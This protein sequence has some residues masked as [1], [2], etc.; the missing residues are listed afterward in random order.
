MKGSIYARESENDTNKAPPIELQVKRGLKW[1][2]ENGY[3]L[4]KAYQDNG[5]SGGDWRRA[6]F[7]QLI[8]DAKRHQ[9]VIVWTWNQDRLARDTEQFLKFYRELKESYVKVYSDTEGWIDMETAGGR[10]KH[11][12]LAMA[13]EAFR[14]I[15]S[16]K[17]KK[18]YQQK[19]KEA[20]NKGL[21]HFWGRKPIKLPLE[22]IK[23]LKQTGL[24][25]RAIAKE[26]S[27]ENIKVSYMTI[28][29]V[30]KNTH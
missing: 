19:R 22:Q 30:L 6:D 3:E 9:F 8:K 28:R 2:Q 16:E 29:N 11:T 13:S 7:N 27:K 1:L 25:Y 15:T 4:F 21:Q 26:L 18:V 5:F 17:V 23:A 24:G 10:I 12:A 14:L 20:L